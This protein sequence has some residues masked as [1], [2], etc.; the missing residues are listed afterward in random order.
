MNYNVFDRLKILFDL[1]TSS[2]FFIALIVIFLLTTFVLLLYKRLKNKILKYVVAVN[3]F[4]I[5][6][7]IVIKYSKTILTLSDNLVDQI[8]TFFY[9]PN[10]IAYLCMI[11]LAILLLIKVL[12]SH[13]KTD[14]IKIVSIISFFNILILFILSLDTIIKNNINIYEKTSVYQNETLTV[15]IQESTFIF[16]IWVFIYV[17]DFI[18]SKIMQNIEKNKFYEMEEKQGD[19]IEKIV[20][21]ETKDED[22]KF[23]SDEEFKD[24]IDR[25]KIYE[26][27]LK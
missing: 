2:P 14:F 26:E 25:K 20:T 12:L 1:I 23:M 9:F 3:Y 16:G 15:L 17:V 5:C 8:F 22:F 4:I 18:A 10:I 21:D 11:I 27:F 13:Y 7:M 6:L 24:S 19:V